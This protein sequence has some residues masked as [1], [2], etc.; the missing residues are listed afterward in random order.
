MRRLT[1]STLF[2]A[3]RT[4]RS[5]R[6]ELY[7]TPCIVTFPPGGKCDA[8]VNPANERLVGTRFT[9]GECARYLAPGTTL[10][11]PPQCVDGLVHGARGDSSV[12]RDSEALAAEL[13]ALPIV[14]GDDVRCPTGGAVATAA[15]GEMRVCYSHLIHVAAPFFQNERWRE[16]LHSTF[17]NAFVVAESIGV[18]TVAVPLCGAG[19]RGAPESDAA[20]VAAVAASDFLAE[21]SLRCVRFALLETA[22]AQMLAEELDRTGC[23][24][25]EDNVAAG[26]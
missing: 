11:Y 26:G 4:P 20:A 25:V 18:E 2:A 6:V 23:V 13:A 7:L 12:P 9:P 22:Q 16:L 21:S 24:R 14:E 3:F 10:I 15:H 17:T 1:P 5:L 8:L 19:A